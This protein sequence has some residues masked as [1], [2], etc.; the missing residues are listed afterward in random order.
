MVTKA[1]KDIPITTGKKSPSHLLSTLHPL[2]EAEQLFERIL[3]RRW[4]TLMR[5]HDSPLLSGRFDEM[6]LRMPH[7]DVIDRENDIVVR[8]EV[9]GID[10]KDL[11]ISITDNLLTIKGQTRTE[12]TEEK[13]DFHRHEISSSSFAR[14]VT[15][16]GPVDASTANAALKDGILEITFPKP[17][18][19]KR[20]NISVA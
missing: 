7:V 17:E 8:A 11:D 20:R 6:A 9:P 1:E 2:S 12:K 15:L 3:G 4:P 18:S 13:G 16:P 14:S 5:W 19:S 10:K